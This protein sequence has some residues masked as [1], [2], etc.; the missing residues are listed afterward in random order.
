MI[1]QL[2][3]VLPILAAGLF[4]VAVAAPVLAPDLAGDPAR[5]WPLPLVSALLFLAWSLHALAEGG[6]QGVW[7]EHVRNAWGNQVWFDLLMATS[8]AWILLLPRIRRAGMRPLPWL[9][10]VAATGCIGLY[11]MLARCLFLESRGASS[12]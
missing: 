7:A 10:A 3:P 1:A 12:A 6:L 9:A 4:L 2:Y 8:L 5:L 11:L